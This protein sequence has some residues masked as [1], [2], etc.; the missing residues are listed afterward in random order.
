MDLLKEEPVISKYFKKDNLVLQDIYKANKEYVPI[1]I[2]KCLYEKIF[3]EPYEELCAYE[4]I[5]NMFSITIEKE[6]SVG[7]KIG[8]GY[9]DKQQDPMNISLSGNL[10]SGRAYFY[11]KYFN[12]KGNRTSL[13]TSKKEQY[14]NGRFSLNMAIKEA[15]VSGI[16]SKELSIST[17]DTLAVLD[18]KDNFSYHAELVDDNGNVIKE[19]NVLPSSI[20]IRVNFDDELYRISNAFVNNDQFTNEYVITFCKRIANLEA[21]KFCKRILH[22]SWSVGNVST[23]ANLIDFDTVSFVNGRHPQYSN[24]YNYKANYF[25][26]ELEGYKIMASLINQEK[27]NNL[28]LNDLMDHEYRRSLVMN[29]CDLIGLEYESHYKK[30]KKQIDLLLEKF[31]FLSRKFVSNYYELYAS[32]N[33]NC[34]IYDFS[35]FFAYYLLKRKKEKIDAFKGIALLLNE[36]S[37]LESSKSEIKEKVDL[38]FSD[39]VESK[40]DI[41]KEMKDALDFIDSY[42]K[43]IKEIEDNESITEIKFKAFIV[44]YPRRHLEKIHNLVNLY[45]T[46]KLCYNDLNKIINSLVNT[47]IRKYN[48]YDGKYL[49]N[50]NI[51]ENCIMYNVL[52]K[53]SYQVVI[54]PLSN[55]NVRFGKIKIDNKEYMLK[56]DDSLG[57]D[58]LCS[59]DIF[60]NNLK[61]VLDNDINILLNGDINKNM[62]LNNY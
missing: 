10:G 34:N 30:Y 38:F 29:F 31:N 57:Y 33:V 52:G 42:E 4:K 20:E 60:Y 43:L 22:G 45:I 37:C 13:A 17:F 47:N 27:I 26:F 56:H 62:V 51:D 24:T 58:C 46:N 25:G 12:I 36:P 8:E 5:K 32:S 19:E 54:V 21:E 61:Q 9:S 18:I 11:G 49:L 44:N 7:E 3:N 2:N 6:N 39:Y 53:D 55:L 15:V 16:L 35:S 48:G 59:E 14:S 23:N 1:Y 28:D 41:E 50:L 40:R